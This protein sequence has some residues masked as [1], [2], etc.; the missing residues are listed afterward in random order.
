MI[1]KRPTV[2]SVTVLP[3][4]LGP[5]TTSVSN[6]SPRYISFET[7]LSLSI[8]G[9]LALMSSTT[10]LSLRIGSFPLQSRDKDALQ[11]QKSR[12]HSIL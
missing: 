2:F 11:N 5:V 3:P 8:K 6:F 9:C 7:T 12:S 10:P 1:E 4:V